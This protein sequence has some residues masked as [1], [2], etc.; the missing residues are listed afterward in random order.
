MA[1]A[2]RNLSETSASPESGES[3]AI[4][5]TL[6]SERANGDRDLLRS[7][8]SGSDL[9]GFLQMLQI[10]VWFLSFLVSACGLKGAAEEIHN[11]LA[12]FEYP[13]ALPWCR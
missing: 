7:L 12:G 6:M 13:A 1:T 9:L 4:R 8:K 11:S 10:V 2:I 5:H 3:K